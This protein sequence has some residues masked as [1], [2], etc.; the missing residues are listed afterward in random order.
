MSV[1][2]DSYADHLSSPRS[3]VPPTLA[4]ITSPNFSSPGMVRVVAC[5]TSVLTVLFRVAMLIC[6]FAEEQVATRERSKRRECMGCERAG[7]EGEVEEGAGGAR[8]EGEG[9][10]QLSDYLSDHRCPG[11]S[12][13]PSCSISRSTSLTLY[14]RLQREQRRK[15]LLQKEKEAAELKKLEENEA[16]RNAAQQAAAL[17][18]QGVV[19]TLP[20]LPVP[21]QL[22]QQVAVP[23]ADKEN[24]TADASAEDDGSTDSEDDQEQRSGAVSSR[25]IWVNVGDA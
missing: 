1:P 19:M 3:R 21:E 7:D 4:H 18:S 10:G 25:T 8:A 2:V 5:M 9:G 6:R 13:G 16:A 24:S 20:P 15:E 11:A 17:L 23:E 12:R 22:V 14:S